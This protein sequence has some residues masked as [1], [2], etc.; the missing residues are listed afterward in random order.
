MPGSGLLTESSL[1]CHP[2]TPPLP[3][4]HP[5][6]FPFPLPLAAFPGSAKCSEPR[7]H[8]VHT[9][10]RGAGER[11]R[12]SDVSRSV[13][14]LRRTSPSGKTRSPFWGW[15]EGGGCHSRVSCSLN[16][17]R[18]VRLPGSQNVPTKI[19]KVPYLTHVQFFLFF[20]DAKYF[21]F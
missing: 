11:V 14:R 3:L 5:L 9:Q 2:P 10:A 15:E 12:H 13:R 16:G 21:N 6:S 7:P 1:P 8:P 20:P 19:Q 4:P 18:G 17:G